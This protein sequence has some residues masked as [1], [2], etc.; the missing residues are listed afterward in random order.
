MQPDRKA[1]IDYMETALFDLRRAFTQT[2]PDATIILCA[3]INDEREGYEEP[4]EDI[5]ASLS[6]VTEANKAFALYEFAKILAEDD[7]ET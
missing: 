2:F 1:R 5:I 3:Y 4:R 6:E 7:E